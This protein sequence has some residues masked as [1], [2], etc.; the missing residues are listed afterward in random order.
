[1]RLLTLPKEYRARLKAAAARHGYGSPDE[2]FETLLQRGLRAHLMPGDPGALP[3]QVAAVSER[4]GYSSP[5]ELVEHLLEQGL[6]PLED[7]ADT[8]A[9]EKRL[10]GLGYIE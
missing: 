4:R 7:P 2:L 10:K 8:A 3:E 1:M 6:R 5:A 9:L